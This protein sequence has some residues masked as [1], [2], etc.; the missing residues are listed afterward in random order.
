MD[1]RTWL[2]RQANDPYVKKAKEQGL[3]ARSAF[4][5]EEIQQKYKIIKPADIVFELGAA[6]GGFTEKIV[7]FVGRKGQVIAIDLL[8]MAPIDDVIFIQGDFTNQDLQNKILE[9][10]TVGK[11]NVI[12]SDMAPN[13]SGIFKVDSLKTIALAEDALYF[14][15]ENLKEN[16]R[17]VVKVF[18]GM[19]FAGYKSMLQNYFVKVSRFKPSSSRSDSKELY[20]IADGLKTT[21]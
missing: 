11:A 3:R 5:I 18:D 10:S 9:Q 19:G 16:G 6:P 13:F 8:A 2:K 7:K 4:K 1:S 20:L 12:I 17:F 15:L 14:T 21:T